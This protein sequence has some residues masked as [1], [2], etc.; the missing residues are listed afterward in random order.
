[1]GYGWHIAIFH[2]FLLP[3]PA[4]VERILLQKSFNVFLQVMYSTQ[5]FIAVKRHFG[6]L[7]MVYK[8]LLLQYVTSA[9]SKF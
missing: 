5:A 8:G 7:P 6:P 9:P 1:M 2:Q 3:G 4:D